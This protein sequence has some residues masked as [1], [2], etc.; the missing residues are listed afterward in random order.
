MRHL[1]CFCES[2]AVTDNPHPGLMFL[3]TVGYLMGWA[4]TS[5]FQVETLTECLLLFFSSPINDWNYVSA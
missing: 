4:K 5:F 1:I 3:G 2:Q